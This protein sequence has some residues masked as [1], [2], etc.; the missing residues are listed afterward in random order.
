[1]SGKFLHVS[2]YRHTKFWAVWRGAELV[3]VTV[4]RKGADSVVRE[5]RKLEAYEARG[6]DKAA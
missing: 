2:R 6:P 5:L 1:M 3:V 4:Y